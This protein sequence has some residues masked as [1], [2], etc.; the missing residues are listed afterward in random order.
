MPSYLKALFL[1]GIISFLI[2]L[3]ITPLIKKIALKLQIVDNPEARKVHKKTTPKM[4]GA[5]I[6]LGFLITI[7][8]MV[9]IDRTILSIL[10]GAT[11]IIFLGIIDDKYTINAWVKL[12]GQVIIAALVIFMGISIRYITNPIN[13]GIFV[14]DWWLSI[15]ITLIWIIG[16]INAINLIDGLDGLA[17]GVSGIAA[18]IIVIIALSTRQY[19]AALLM[20]ALFG[21]NLG[22]LRYNFAPA[23]LFMG[24]T[25]SMFLGFTLATVT[26][27][28][29]MKSSITLALFIPLLIFGIPIFDT[30]FAIA[31]R[32]K[33]KKRIFEADRSHL[34]HRLLDRGLSQKQVVIFIYVATFLLGLLAWLISIIYR[35]FLI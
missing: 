16:L 32:I 12:L 3:V 2:T 7:L 26:V 29:V 35:S 8:I 25:G 24:D 5:A 13:G 9:P 28:G 14:L 19:T 30:L 1:S 20:M 22:F 4:G 10:I 27:S 23:K 21:A 15:P 34:H 31:R 18:L 11:L 6:Y 17:S 33:N